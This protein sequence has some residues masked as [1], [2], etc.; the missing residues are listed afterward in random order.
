MVGRN[1]GDDVACEHRLREDLCT[2]SN[3]SAALIYILL[4]VIVTWLP[5]PLN[6]P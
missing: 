2:M 4:V 6:W 5:M 1:S 3:I